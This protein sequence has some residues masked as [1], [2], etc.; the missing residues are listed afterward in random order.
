VLHEDVGDGIGGRRGLLLL[1]LAHR[2][3]L[4]R[5]VGADHVR[6]DRDDHG[7]LGGRHHHPVA[8]RDP[9]AR[10]G[11]LTRRLHLVGGL[12]G[13]GL[14]V[15]ALELDGPHAGHGQEHAEGDHEDADPHAGAPHWEAHRL[16]VA[17]G[18]GAARGPA[19]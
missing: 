3:A 17:A 6:V 15:D 7:R 13:E 18:R 19:S 16:A 5:A 9:A 10:G 11:Q 8:V 2:V 4:V 14:R 1:L 12:R